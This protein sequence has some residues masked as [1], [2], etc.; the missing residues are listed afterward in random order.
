MGGGAPGPQY[1]ASRGYLLSR[2]GGYV[3]GSIRPLMP[4]ELLSRCAALDGS[5]TRLCPITIF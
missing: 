4:A 1:R 3:L 2:M 5:G